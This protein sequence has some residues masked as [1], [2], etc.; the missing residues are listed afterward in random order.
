[1]QSLRAI[2]EGRY[3]A[4]TLVPDQPGEM[5]GSTVLADE[6]IGSLDHR[7]LQGGNLT[8]RLLVGENSAATGTSGLVITGKVRRT[9]RHH[10]EAGTYAAYKIVLSG[11]GSRP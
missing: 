9:L 8:V 7:V 3:L 1:M 5:A 11:V 4:A 2:I 6:K 10:G